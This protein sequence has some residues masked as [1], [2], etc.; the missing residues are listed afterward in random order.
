M[1]NRHEQFL[2]IYK[3]HRHDDQ[4]RF[5]NARHSEFEKARR[6]A[7]ILTG[8]LMFLTAMVS[9]LTAAS[10]QPKPLWVV[11]S[12]ILPAIS[13]ALT[14]YTS[15]FAFDQQSKLYQD[16]FRAL[17]KAEASVYG[18]KQALNETDYKAGLEIYVNQVEEVFRKEQGQW[19]QLVSEMKTVD[20][21]KL[22]K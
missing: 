18:L 19:G 16:A 3:T 10:I 13:T 21:P 6:Q 8:A 20:P 7:V 15:L 17:H 2:D 11:L 4:A 14:A 1:S 5:Y 12:V 9:V 22:K